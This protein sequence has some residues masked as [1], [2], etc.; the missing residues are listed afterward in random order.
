MRQ[1]WMAAALGVLA[2]MLGA[3]GGA[4]R[5]EGGSA[6]PAMAPPPP[7]PRLAGSE[8]D[9]LVCVVRDG[10]L[11]LV[12]VDYDT[13]TGDTLVNGRPF[14]EVYPDT[15]GYA[16]AAQW[17]VDNEPITINRRRHVKYGVP[18]VLGVHELTRVGEYRG[19]PLFVAAGADIRAD[20]KYVPVR[21][22][23]EFQPYDGHANV[24]AVRG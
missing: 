1:V 7:A 14:A 24:G 18:R 11:Q 22:G 5:E 4:A 17:Y 16:G 19:V 2:A 8:R 10:D 21:P 23:C 15:V 3:C 6:T 13:R 9:I 12:R 20:I